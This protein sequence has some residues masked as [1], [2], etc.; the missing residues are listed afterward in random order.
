MKHPKF[1]QI[2]GAATGVFAL[3]ETGSVWAFGV[4]ANTGTEGWAE[5]T[6]H[7]FTLPDVERN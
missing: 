6:N 5:M 4:E 3:D 7:R 2:T 1:V